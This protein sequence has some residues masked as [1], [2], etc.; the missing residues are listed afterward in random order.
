MPL[1]TIR[2]AD[3]TQ[4]THLFEVLTLLFGEEGEE[5]RRLQ[6]YKQQTLFLHLEGAKGEFPGTDVVL[7]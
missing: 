6:G 3:H 2:L 4:N 5:R 1:G 7:L